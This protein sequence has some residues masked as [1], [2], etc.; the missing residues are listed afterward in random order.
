MDEDAEL[1]GAHVA[2]AAGQGGQG[3]LPREP[4]R[5]PD[6]AAQSR[7]HGEPSQHRRQVATTVATTCAPH[8]VRSRGDY[9]YFFLCRAF[10]IVERL[11]DSRLLRYRVMVPFLR[12]AILYS[13]R[14]DRIEAVRSAIIRRSVAFIYK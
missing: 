10:R 4:E 14:V 9:P 3:R 13:C 7:E 11:C 5:Q 12:F 8:F 6:L 1:P 2:P